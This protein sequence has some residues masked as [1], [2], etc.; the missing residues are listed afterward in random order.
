[1]TAQGPAT[2]SDRG[3]TAR[4]SPVG[5][6]FHRVRRT[7]RPVRRPHARRLSCRRPPDR[8]TRRRRLG[9]LAGA[10][11]I[12]TGWPQAWRLWAGRRHEG[13]SL[14]SNVLGVL[15]CTAWLLYGVANHS[16]VQVATNVLGL[17]GLVAILAG[18]LTLARPLCGSGC[19][20]W[21]AGSW[22]CSPSS[23]L[24]AR[25]LG[26]DRVGRDHQWRAA[27]GGSL[28]MAR[29]AGDYDASGVSRTRWRLSCAANLLW[30]SY[31]LIV[32][33]PVI[34]GNSS[35]IAVLGAAIVVLAAAP[36]RAR[37]STWC[38]TPSWPSQPDPAS[39]R[40]RPR[41]N[42]EPRDWRRWA[43]TG[44][45]G[46]GASTAWVLPDVGSSHGRSADGRPCRRRRPQP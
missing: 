13:L 10:I 38:P 39:S 24:G 32:G 45:R 17:V 7:T 27:A 8:A 14:S 18:H 23:S 9:W 20:C 41:Y 42:L 26:L 34:I 16:V 6:L 35:V 21:W 3:R 29:R 11:G 1:M 37:R 46:C 15:Y 31:G 44:K 28:A 4:L 36:G 30:V 25:P 22:C 40:R 19:R 5:E 33:D 43:T 2:A 12:G